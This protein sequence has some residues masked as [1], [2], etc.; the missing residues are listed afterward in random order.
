M[1]LYIMLRSYIVFWWLQWF[2]RCDY[3]VV[4]LAYNAINHND[5]KRSEIC[6][7]FIVIL[8]MESLSYEMLGTQ[9]Y[10]LFLFFFL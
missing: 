9:V 2:T 10:T 3:G 7:N 1:P 8:E 5:C 4:R 6:V